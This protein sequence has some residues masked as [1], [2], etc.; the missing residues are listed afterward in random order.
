MWDN[1]NNF[2]IKNLGAII[3]IVI[4]GILACTQLYRGVI[5]VIAV[6]IG[7]RIGAYAQYHKE[8]LK[9]K[10]KNFIDKL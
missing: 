9:E 1:N 6:Y 10:S 4:G 3:G 5:F 8:E 7:G 2:F